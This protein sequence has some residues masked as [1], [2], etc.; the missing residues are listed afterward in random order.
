[1]RH[2]GEATQVTRRFKRL[3]VNDQKALIEFLKSL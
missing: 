3:K 2:L 1:L